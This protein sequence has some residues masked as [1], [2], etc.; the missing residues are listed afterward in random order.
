M[1][2][3]KFQAGDVVTVK[4]TSEDFIAGSP[5]VVWQNDAHSVNVSDSSGHAWLP[6]GG[7]YRFV[8]WTRQA[9]TQVPPAPTTPAD[10]ALAFLEAHVEARGNYPLDPAK[11][12]R[13]VYGLRIKATVTNSLVAL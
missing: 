3:T 13:E 4:E 6:N 7:F 5:Y 10:R 2:Y 8:L 9:D 11:M 1:A 12:L